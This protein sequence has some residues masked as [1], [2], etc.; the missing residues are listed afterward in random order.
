MTPQAGRAAEAPRIFTPEY[1]RRMR[2]LERL[3]WWNAGMRDVAALL[4]ERASLG[5]TGLLVDVGCGSGQTMTW[6]AGAHPGWQTVGVDLA[7]DALR[8]A[9]ALGATAVLRGSATALPLRSRSADLVITL[10]VLQHLPLD[11]GDRRALSEIARVLKPGGHLFLRTNAQSFP[12][13]DDDRAFD[14]HKYGRRELRA[15]L[16]EAGFEVVRLG[17]LNALL[18]LAEIPRELRSKRSPHSYTGLMSQPRVE[19]RW[20]WTAK[21]RLLAFEG[22]SVRR[23]VDWPLGRTIVALCR[24]PEW[25]SL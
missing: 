11:G 12:R 23:G 3:S 4:L 6:F 7:Q 8:A 21:R 24:L 25:S 22:R 13:R 14:F 18:G 1:Y 15:K 10:D 9:R 16:A 5:P 2:D 19:A 20:L 17:R